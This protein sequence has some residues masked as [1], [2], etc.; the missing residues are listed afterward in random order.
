MKPASLESL[1]DD[2][3]SWGV[4][5]WWRLE[6]RSFA[7]FPHVQ[8]ALAVLSPREAWSKEHGRPSLGGCLQTLAF[9]ASLVTPTIAAALLITWMADGFGA[10][11]LP[12][13]GLL[14]LVSVLVNVYS[15]VQGRRRPRA[16]AIGAVRRVSLVHIVPASAVLALAALAAAGDGRRSPEP[17]VL[18]WLLP[19]LIDLA[20]HVHIWRRG[21]TRPGGPQDPVENVVR[22]VHELDHQQRESIRAARDAAIDRLLLQGKIDADAMTRAQRTE[23]GSLA[24]TVAPEGRSGYHPASAPDDSRP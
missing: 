9:V 11:P 14:F 1:V 15:E 19:V 5:E 7:D 17:P 4:V 6:L 8:R 18:L 10:M 3:S 2:S 23:I 20:L 13:V 21:A 22:A 24:L 16:V 12:Q